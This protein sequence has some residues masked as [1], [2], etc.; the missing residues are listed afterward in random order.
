MVT[1]DG[2]RK[3]LREKFLAFGLDKFTDDEIVELLFTLGTPRRDCKQ[4]AREAIRRFGGL[5][6]TLEA[7]PEELE[8]IP[9]VG[10]NN[11]IGVRLIQAIARK[12]LRE[13]MLRGEFI[14]SFNDVL[15]YFAHTLR[16]EK[17]EAIHLLFLNAQ[18]VIVGEERLA[19][20]SSASVALTPR[21]ALE[22]AV[23]HGAVNVVMAHNHPG[24]APDPSE[25]DIRLTRRLYVALRHA[26]IWLRE[27]LII[28]PDHYY[29]FMREGMI[30]KFEQE[31]Q[32]LSGKLWR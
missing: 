7:Q 24:G 2:H 25:Q 17:T 8:K 23:A 15:D 10:P 12:Y 28:A 13:R 29:S 21:M 14:N 5:A 9:G 32:K 3:R 18:N 27:H 6:R 4:M 16:G 1:G 30:E 11:V 31:F 19:S 26:D 20:G 22:K